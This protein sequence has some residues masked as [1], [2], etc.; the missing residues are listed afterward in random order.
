MVFRVFTVVV[1]LMAVVILQYHGFA[2]WQLQAGTM[3]WLW[4]LGIEGAAV[5]FWWRPQR[6]VRTLGL[7]ASLLS[8][9][10]PLYQV[11]APIIEEVQKADANEVALHARANV[12]RRTLEAEMES[13]RKY[14]QLAET[15]IGWA[16]RIDE[17]QGRIDAT[18]EELAVL[19]S[20]QPTERPQMVQW[21]VIMEAGALVLLQALVVLAVRS[22]AVKGKL[23]KIQPHP[24]GTVSTSNVENVH[25][26]VEEAQDKC[27]ELS[28]PL[29]LQRHLDARGK[30]ISA[31]A[32]SN[33]LNIDRV[34][35]VLAGR[36]S[37]DVV[38]QVAEALAGM[39]DS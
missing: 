5:W 25:K 35:Q 13:L 26:D 2:F 17:A 9:A 39:R 10:G 23:P 28:V 27:K 18:T 38:Q 31:W 14:Q 22:L 12:L 36:A 37:D 29:Q 11:G 15:R 8:L 21:V 1:A 19:M 20:A 6:L 33:G 34:R 24:I 7:I 30:T 32:R 3:G 16:G 4:A